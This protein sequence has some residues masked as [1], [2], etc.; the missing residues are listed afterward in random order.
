M[1]WYWRITSL[2]GATTLSITTFSIATHSI[3][4]ENVKLSMMV[5]ETVMPSV[6]YAERPTKGY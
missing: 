2:T 5:H 4:I 6:I 1:R 3:T